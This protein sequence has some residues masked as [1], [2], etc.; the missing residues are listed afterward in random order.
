VLKHRKKEISIV[1]CSDEYI[2][3]MNKQ[4]LNH[5]YY[6]DIITYH[7]ENTPNNLEAELLISVERIAENAITNKI[8]FEHELARIIIH[9]CLH[10]NG[11]DDKTPKLKK[12]M[13][14]QEDKYLT[15]VSNLLNK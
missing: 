9:G 12:E 8:P 3:Q 15:E 7:Y 10:L 13:T 5:D 4:S 2:L 1:A 6:T 14:N 11:Y